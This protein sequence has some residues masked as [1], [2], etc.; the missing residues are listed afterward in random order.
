MPAIAL[1][2]VPHLLQEVPVSIHPV[3]SA[4]QRMTM[5]LIEAKLLR[6]GSNLIDVYPVDAAVL[7]QVIE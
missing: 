3:M 2:K 5:L 4:S 7:D 6:H 1:C